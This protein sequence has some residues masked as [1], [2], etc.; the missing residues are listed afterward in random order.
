[1]T[2]NYNDDLNKTASKKVSKYYTPPVL[3][4]EIVKRIQPKLGET[5]Y[6]PACGVG[7]LLVSAY[8][9]IAKKRGLTEKDHNTLRQ[10]TFFGR[11]IDDRTFNHAK[12]IFGVSELNIGNLWKGDTLKRSGDDNLPAKY[13]LVLCN[14]PY[15]EWAKEAQTKSVDIP[16]RFIELLFLQHVI[17]SLKHDGIGC[18]VLPYSF[19][20]R[21]E[22]DFREV[23]RKLFV[24]CDVKQ[25]IH[26]DNSISQ[27]A[28]Q[29]RILLIFQYGKRTQKFIFEAPG[30][31]PLIVDRE[32]VEVNHYNLTPAPDVREAAPDDEN[33]NFR[34]RDASYR[35]FISYRH[36]DT[37]WTAAW[38]YDGLKQALDAEIFYDRRSINH[39][40]NWNEKIM[41]EVKD[42]NVFI[43]LIGNNWDLDRLNKSD[44]IVR[45]E[46]S[47]ALNLGKKVF[48]ILVDDAKLPLKEQLPDELHPLLGI[49]ATSLTTSNSD[50]FVEEFIRNT[51]LRS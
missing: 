7:T 4:E 45:L 21:T 33:W 17:K 10:K 43:P 46:I 36:K 13:D 12:E 30:E 14:A 29:E 23:K 41:D 39:G 27:S 19:I 22:D 40:E 48:P 24:E 50:R 9:H 34:S 1:M 8:R 49:Q 11:E 5:V 42:C 51:L 47:N 35:I 15:G 6:D 25:V 18:I 38:L 16:S 37:A 44:D 2:Q 31:K 26:L 32:T 3:A 20:S 28:P